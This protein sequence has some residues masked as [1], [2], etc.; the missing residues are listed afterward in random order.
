MSVLRFLT[1]LSL[2]VWIGGIVFFAFV[3]APVLFAILPTRDLAGAVV[4]RLLGALH[5]MGIVAAVVFVITSMAWS[6]MAAGNVR[7]FAAKHVLVFVMLVLTLIS[8]FG[9]SA[10]MRR[11]RSEMGS[12]DN[13]AASDLHRVEFNRLHRWSTMLESGVLLLGLITIYLVA[14]ETRYAAPST[15]YRVPSAE[16]SPIS[17]ADV[18]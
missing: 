6:A 7:L 12:V 17:A 15:Q 13:V 9:V 14:A 5:W 18:H 4:T 10:R 8:Q 11:L 16:K 3:V 2:V 1:L